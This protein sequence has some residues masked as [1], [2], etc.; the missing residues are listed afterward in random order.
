MSHTDHVAHVLQILE[1]IAIP[2]DMDDRE[3]LI[4]A[5]TT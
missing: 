2:V 3:S 1:G 4:R 5:A